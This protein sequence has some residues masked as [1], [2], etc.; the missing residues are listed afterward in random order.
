ML[1]KGYGKQR[2]NRLFFLKHLSC[3]PKNLFLG[4]GQV[5]C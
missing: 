2:I 3:M 4:M 5:K 1:I